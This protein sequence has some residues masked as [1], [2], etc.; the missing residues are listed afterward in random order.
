MTPDTLRLS[1]AP[2]VIPRG[3]VPGRFQLLIHV[4]DVEI[5]SAAD[6]LGV[7]PFPVFHP[8]NLLG[9]T[10][11][12]H[13]VSLSRCRCA[14]PACHD[15]KDTITRD[16][17]FV[18]WDWGKWP[19]MPRRATFLASHYDAEVS[20]CASDHSW[21]TPPDT[22]ARLVVTRSDRSHLASY[23]LSFDYLDQFV[24]HGE[25]FE[26]PFVGD[27][28]QVLLDFPWQD[29]SPADLAAEVCATLALPPQQW[30][31]RWSPNEWEFR[32]DGKQPDIAGPTWRKIED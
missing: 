8:V 19:L 3:P 29:R 2:L 14:L 26:V 5:T 21:E 31:A 11:V 9:A 16:G 7:D 20:R 28:Y 23:D 24:S 30:D 27:G 25:V 32:E 4:N 17:E 10:A 12:P 13:T 22:A 18:H 6:N 1:I 15:S